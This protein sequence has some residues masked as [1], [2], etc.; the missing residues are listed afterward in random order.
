MDLARLPAVA[1]MFSDS[2]GNDVPSE[3]GFGIHSTVARGAAA[4]MQWQFNEP[5][6]YLVVF[7]WLG[8]HMGTDHGAGCYLQDKPIDLEAYWSN[9]VKANP[10]VRNGRPRKQYCWQPQ[11]LLGQF[12]QFLSGRSITAEMDNNKN[13]QLVVTIADK[14]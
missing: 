13:A 2:A 5:E 10:D 9:C 12:D 3:E 1:P 8:Q 4:L 14:R 6:L 11:G 7:V